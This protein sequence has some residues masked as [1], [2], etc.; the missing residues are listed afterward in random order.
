MVLLY[1]ALEIYKF[2][3]YYIFKKYACE[4]RSIINCQINRPIV[5]YR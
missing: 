5:N 3:L 1:Y 4:D 2:R